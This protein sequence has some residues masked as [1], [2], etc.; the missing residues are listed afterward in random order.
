MEPVD[1]A[2]HRGMS[3][4]FG[5]QVSVESSARFDKC[6]RMVE[7]KKSHAELCEVNVSL[8]DPFPNSDRYIVRP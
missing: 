8:T 4:Q 3:Q 6:E 1:F 7:L 5:R 2:R